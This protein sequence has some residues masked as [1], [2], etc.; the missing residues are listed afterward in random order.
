MKP[1]KIILIYLCFFIF[2]IPFVEIACSD[3]SAFSDQSNVKQQYGS[4][5]KQLTK[6]MNNGSIEQVESITNQMKV[7]LGENAGI[8]QKPDNV[9]YFKQ[10]RT[11]SNY[12]KNEVKGLLSSLLKKID[13]SA[14]EYLSKGE[15]T[16]GAPPSVLLRRS[17]NLITIAL[18]ACQYDILPEI[19]DS[20]AQYARTG[21]ENLMA[22]QLPDGSFP[23]PDL[24][25]SSDKL[26]KNIERQL[27][28]GMIRVE[29][30][31]C[32]E[33]LGFGGFQMDA[34][35]IGHTMLRAYRYFNTSEYLDSAI[36]AAEWS[37]D[38]KPVPN[39]NYNAFS[40]NLLASLY[41]E[42]WQPEYL[43]ASIKKMQLGVLPGQS[44][45]GRWIDSHNALFQ[46]HII[47]INALLK[48][49]PALETSDKKHRNQAVRAIQ[50]GL[51]P[52]I[53]DNVSGIITNPPDMLVILLNATNNLGPNNKA[54]QAINANLNAIMESQNKSTSNKHPNLN[55]VRALITYLYQDYKTH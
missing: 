33:D 28:N 25:N 27:E 6:A 41:R 23:S 53:K 31:W 44:R 18:M 43:D 12:T 15:K 45:T 50:Q 46:Y 54:N 10:T 3:Q 48:V 30:G 21:L 40:M 11:S 16:P 49:Y 42:T 7:L 36:K 4:L 14:I 32:V 34:G 55:V 24:R 51:L 37:K 9:R 38:F 26:A 47:I 17:A 39:W 35:I 2:Q 19:T 29:N 22:L 8:P 20:C 5:E 1:Q 13:F 52:I